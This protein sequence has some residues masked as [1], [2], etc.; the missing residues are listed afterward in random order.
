M[1]LSAHHTGVGD[2]DGPRSVWLL[3]WPSSLTAWGS[4][5]SLASSSDQTM[6]VEAITLLRVFVSGLRGTCSSWAH[7][8]F[9]LLQGVLSAHEKQ[10]TDVHLFLKDLLKAVPF[11][12]FS[13]KNIE[14]VCAPMEFVTVL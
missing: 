10:V 5:L 11:F 12:F 6:R 2:G 8:K 13:L 1:L 9:S 7:R 14:A 4:A 3:L